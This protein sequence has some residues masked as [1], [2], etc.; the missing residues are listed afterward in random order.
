MGLDVWGSV[1]LAEEFYYLHAAGAEASTE[2][3]VGFLNAQVRTPSE[4]V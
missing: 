2:A 3:E 4:T 1:D